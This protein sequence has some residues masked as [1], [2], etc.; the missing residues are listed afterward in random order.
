MAWKGAG[1]ADCCS[2]DLHKL[3]QAMFAQ[4]CSC[5][6]LTDVSF[7]AVA[8]VFTLFRRMFTLGC[9]KNEVE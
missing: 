8:V 3:S 7:W 2:C 6:S 5:L 9:S 1:S 4:L